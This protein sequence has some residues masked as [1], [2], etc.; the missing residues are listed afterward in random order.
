MFEYVED[1]HTRSFKV[2]P[3]ILIIQ[4]YCRPNPHMENGNNFGKS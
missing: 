3:Q 2:Y 4:Y 1:K